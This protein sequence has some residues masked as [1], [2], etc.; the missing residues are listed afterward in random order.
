MEQ[1]NKILADARFTSNYDRQITYGLYQIKVELNTTHRDEET[2][3]IIYD[4]PNLNGNIKALAEL[5]K[6]YYNE[7]IV[8]LLFKYQLLK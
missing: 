7:E 8:P 5:V 1:W 4:Y 2:N 6:S 3:E